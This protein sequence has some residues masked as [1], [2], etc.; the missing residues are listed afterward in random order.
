MVFARNKQAAAELSRQSRERAMDKC[1]MA[2]AEGTFQQ[3]SGELK[4]Y[5]MR[6]GKSNISRVV[7]QVTPGAKQAKLYYEVVEVWDQGHN[8]QKEEE[9]LSSLQQE[10]RRIFSCHWQDQREREVSLLQIKLET[11]RHHQIRVQM[12]H[13]GHPLV[14]DKKYNPSCQKGCLPVA[15]C[16]VSLAFCHPRN[17]KSMEFR[18]H[19]RH[20]II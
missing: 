6:E 4:D 20:D 9:D 5:L 10:G 12:A 7:S 15:L 3:S 17:G 19:S 14:G 2:L 13:A 18:L 1:Y 11:G 8:Q 16:S